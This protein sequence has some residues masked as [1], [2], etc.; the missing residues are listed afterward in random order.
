M[1]LENLKF[2][3]EVFSILQNLQYKKPGRVI[4]R[5]RKKIEGESS[6]RVQY[7]SIVDVENLQDVKKLKGRLLI[8]L[9]VHFGG[10]RL[11]DN[12]IVN[13]G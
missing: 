5:M 10:T 8:A 3:Q 6:G 4:S 12:I 13:I 11:I 9:A 2:N 7:I 1:L